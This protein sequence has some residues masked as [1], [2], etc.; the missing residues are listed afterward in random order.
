MEN[1]ELKTEMK[2]KLSVLWVEDEN[3]IRE[4]IRQLIELSGHYCDAVNSGNAAMEHLDKNSYDI[5]ITDI[6]MHGMNGWEL[7]KLIKEKYNGTMPVAVASGWIITE[8]DKITHGI[9]YV[10]SKPFTFAQVKKLFLDLQS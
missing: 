6:G 5:V 2:K 1:L 7:A 3:V 8:E 10:L 4:N 9:K